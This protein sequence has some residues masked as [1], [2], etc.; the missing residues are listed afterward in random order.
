MIKNLLFLSICFVIMS[1]S[2]PAKTEEIKNEGVSPTSTSVSGVFATHLKLGEG[3]FKIVS[4]GSYLKLTIPIEVTKQYETNERWNQECISYKAEYGV[5]RTFQDIMNEK[6]KLSL[7]LLD[8]NNAPF[9]DAGSFD[10]GWSRDLSNALLKGSSGQVYVEFSNSYLEADSLRQ[11]SDL[12]MLMKNAVTFTVNSTLN[13]DDTMPGQSSSSE[14]NPQTEGN[15]IAQTSGAS[16]SGSC[17]Q[18]LNDY[19][20][21]VTK[22]ISFMRKYKKNPADASMLS[23]YSR[24]TSEMSKWSKGNSGCN[25]AASVA[26]M[27]QIANRMNTALASL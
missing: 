21:W 13:F 17:Q 15:P 22:Y 16:S 4:K 5:E 7:T 3:K 24:L 14:N 19:D 20:S 25:D 18:W 27:T 10:N 2:T 8:A 1:C 11:K 26:R 6:Y 9:T 23:D 12:E